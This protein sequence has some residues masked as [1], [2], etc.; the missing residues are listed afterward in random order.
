MTALIDP[1][2]P[3]HHHRKPA[4]RRLG[5]SPRVGL[6]DGML[7]K[8]GGWGQGMLDAAEAVLRSRFPLARFA[9]ESINPLDNP[10]PD[11]FAAAMAEHYDA[12]VV[13][14]GDCVTCVSRG[15]RDAI[16]AELAGL[17]SAVVC[18]AAVEEVVRHVCATYGMPALRVFQV[19][20]SL[21]GQSR[22]RIATLVAP[23]LDE[24]PD[25]LTR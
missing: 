23:Y 12:L 5:T 18:T 17:P 1:T 15:V 19:R 2:A 4:S 21:I 3:R 24:L 9:R 25:A 10:P 22:E 11:L 6:V 13:V 20:E 14:G 8:R 7:N 16:W